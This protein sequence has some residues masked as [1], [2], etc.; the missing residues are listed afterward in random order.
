MGCSRQRDEKKV[1]RAY[2]LLPFVL[3]EAEGEGTVTPTCWSGCCGGGSPGDGSAGGGR[4]GGS[5][6]EAGAGLLGVGVHREF[7]NPASGPR[8]PASG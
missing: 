4:G 1:K 5:A 6:E 2:G 8:R 3:E 7:R